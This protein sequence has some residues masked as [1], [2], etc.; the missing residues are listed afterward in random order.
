VQG[1]YLRT[2]VFGLHQNMLRASTGIV[3]RF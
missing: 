1:D 3:V 2:N